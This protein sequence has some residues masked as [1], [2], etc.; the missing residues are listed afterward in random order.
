M[1]VNPKSSF[2]VCIDTCQV[3]PVIQR[4]QHER[5]NKVPKNI[6]KHDLEIK[7][8]TPTI[9]DSFIRLMREQQSVNHPKE[10]TDGK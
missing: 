10:T 9:E 7:K 3:H 2:Q 6:T 5:D 1:G 8:I 4:E